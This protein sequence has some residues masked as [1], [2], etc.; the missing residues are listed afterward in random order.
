M[1]SYRFENKKGVVEFY[2]RTVNQRYDA[3]AVTTITITRRDGVV[4]RIICCWDYECEKLG[5][6]NQTSE[7]FE[8]E[9]DVEQWLKKHSLPTMQFVNDGIHQLNKNYHEDPMGHPSQYE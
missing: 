9:Q 7:R 1:P 6:K 3:T 5:G 2:E 4:F 8:R